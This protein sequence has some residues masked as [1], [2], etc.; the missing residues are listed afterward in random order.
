MVYAVKEVKGLLL[1]GKRKGI[2]AGGYLACICLQEHTA[3]QDEKDESFPVW[4]CRY[5]YSAFG[6]NSV[7]KILKYINKKEETNLSQWFVSH[8]SCSQSWFFYRLRG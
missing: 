2:T 1:R 5:Q 4:I 3:S 7:F 6:M 8:T